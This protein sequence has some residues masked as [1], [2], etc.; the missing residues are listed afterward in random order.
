MSYKV[1]SERVADAGGK[2]VSS[3]TGAMRFDE[4]EEA[5]SYARFNS[6]DDEEEKRWVVRDAAGNVVAVYVEGRRQ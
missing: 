6:D 1:K 3:A 2:P 5:E 4:L